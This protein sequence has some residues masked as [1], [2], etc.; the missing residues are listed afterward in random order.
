MHISMI[1]NKYEYSSYSL[2]LEFE[3]RMAEKWDFTKDARIC[4]KPL[5]QSSLLA[6][7][8]QVSICL[9]RSLMLVISRQHLRCESGL[10]NNHFL[11]IQV[12]L[13]SDERI[14]Q[15]IEE[16]EAKTT[17]ALRQKERAEGIAK[18]W[19]LPW[20]EPRKGAM[21]KNEPRVQNEARAVC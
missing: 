13:M 10:K 15:T 19:G 16:R 1:V 11:G 6:F 18:K 20:P 7:T 5:K 4:A 17:A 14:Q 21:G 2:L 3:L 12:P 8:Q 9:L